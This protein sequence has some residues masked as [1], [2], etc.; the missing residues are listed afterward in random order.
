LQCHFLQFEKF[1]STFIEIEHFDLGQR[2]EDSPLN[3]YFI[4]TRYEKLGPNLTHFHEL[5]LSTNRFTNLVP[6]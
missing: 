1:A 5:M 6:Q 4:K 2:K 3:Q